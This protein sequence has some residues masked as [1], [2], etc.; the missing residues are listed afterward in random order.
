MST[1]T[2]LAVR[3]ILIAFSPLMSREGFA[4]DVPITDCDRLAA[5]DV[6]QQKLGGGVPLESIKSDSAI[7]A[8]LDASKQYP[9]T[10]RFVFQLGRAYQKAK[11][12]DKSMEAYKQAADLGYSQSVVAVGTLFYNGLGV[13]RNESHGAEWF[14][15]AAD[16][17]NALGQAFTGQ[18]LKSGRGVKKDVSEAVQWFRLSADNG[19]PVGQLEMAKSYF[20]GIGVP[21]DD[22]EAAKWAR[23][24]A[25]QG[26]S[27]AQ[28][29]L[30]YLTEKGRGTSQDFAGAIKLYKSAAEQGNAIAANN[31]GNMYSDGYG[32]TKDQKEALKWYRLAAD[33]GNPKAQYQLGKS[34]EVGQGVRDDPKE[35]VK[36]YRLA[37][38]G[39][40][41]NG[42]TRL[43]QLL[44]AGRGVAKNSGE[45]L[46]WF[47]LAAAQGQ[48]AAQNDL[49]AMYGQ[50]EGVPQ[51][52]AEAAKWYALSAAQGDSVAQFNL[53]RYLIL[54]KGV[55]QDF[56]Q[57]HM[58]LNLASSRGMDEAKKL[59]DALVVKMNA[60]QIDKAQRM[61]RLCQASQFK[62]C[63]DSANGGLQDDRTRTGN[64]SD[65]SVAGSSSKSSGSGFFVSGD[66]YIIT[67]EHV[68][69]SCGKLVATDNSGDRLSLRFV[70]A[71]TSDDLALLKADT[72]R[73]A[74][75]RIR[76]SGRVNQGEAVALYGFPLIGLLASSGNV[77]T[78]F[79]TALAGIKDNDRQLQISAPVQ[80]G[81]SGG[82]LVD[83]RANVVGVIVAK[84]NA[85]AVANVTDDIP[86]N[87]NFAIKASSV[88]NLLDLG[89]VNYQ[90]SAQ[91]EELNLEN[92]TKK[93]RQFTVLI[94]CY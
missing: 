31:L 17:G 18:A 65:R 28:L 30:G 76:E 52:F 38:E 16:K 82:P 19:N 53:A 84:L 13:P 85:I 91:T 27:S 46:K 5:S 59:R 23:K 70:R 39:G 72:S 89:N 74:F 49:G 44:L 51:D 73:E 7:S 48:P 93:I 64:R 3:V 41:A 79:V 58:W 25:D 8:C 56:V 34:Y 45:A 47:K 14:R 86:Q 92:L 2:N 69:K 88:I 33:L 40:N 20:E 57:A 24:S 81:N 87:I 68:I 54:G 50:G 60:Q 67:N 55:S 78:G 26:Y 4:Q 63:G 36:W 6:D 66:G 1:K 37:A 35:A 90:S 83:F 22:T 29:Y 62:D 75:A 94:E 71:S 11:L 43:A 15:K 61:A 42:Q 12:F 32:V 77:S 80:P 10:A 9:S 21:Q